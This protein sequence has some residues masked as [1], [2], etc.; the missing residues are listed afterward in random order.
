MLVSYRL[1]NITFMNFVN[2]QPLTDP[3]EELSIKCLCNNKKTINTGIKAMIYPVATSLVLAAKA[4][5]N[6]YNPNV[7]G[8]LLSS[9][10]TSNGQRKLF[11][12]EIKLKIPKVA[13]IGLTIGINIFHQI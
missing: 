10:N 2:Y 8:V 13:I 6:L 9:F 3:D 4:P 11:Q 1:Y 7:N 12:A 5:S